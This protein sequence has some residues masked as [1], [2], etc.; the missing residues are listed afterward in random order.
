MAWPAFGGFRTENDHP[1]MWWFICIGSSACKIFLFCVWSQPH[2]LKYIALSFLECVCF[3]FLKLDFSQKGI[4]GRVTGMTEQVV[5]VSY[6]F[7]STRSASFAQRIPIVLSVR[8]ISCCFFLS[9]AMN[10]FVWFIQ[11]TWI[12]LFVAE[13]ANCLLAFSHLPL[14]QPSLIPVLALS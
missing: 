12:V 6:G 4:V 3:L 8:L 9:S 14:T 1:F 10:L 13:G 5:F 11:L 7:V 2:L